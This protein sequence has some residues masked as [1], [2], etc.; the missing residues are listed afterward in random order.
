MTDVQSV[1][2]TPPRR[3]GRRSEQPDSLNFDE[4]AA[5]LKQIVARGSSDA[6]RIAELAYL[7]EPKYGDQTLVKLAKKIGGGIAACALERRRRVFRAW[8]Q[9]PAA[10][11]KSFAVAQE[12]ETLPP[13]VAA[14]I[15]TDKPDISSREARRKKLEHNGQ[16]QQMDPEFAVKSMR[17]L[18]T[19]LLLRAS[20]AVRDAEIINFDLERQ[21]SLRAVIITQPAVLQELREAAQA[22]TTLADFLQHLVDA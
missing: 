21:R 18:F 1:G 8:K 12:L 9:I 17:K 3:R 22:W 16:V 5:E 20:K 11:P 14:Q 19:Q 2:S 4:V 6:W 15:I 13:E 7:V 10:P